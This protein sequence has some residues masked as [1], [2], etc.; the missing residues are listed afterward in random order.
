MYDINYTCIIQC[1]I[2]IK[3][4]IPFIVIIKYRLYPLYY[5]IYPTYKTV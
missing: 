1:L 3:D 5:T 2:I 4:Y